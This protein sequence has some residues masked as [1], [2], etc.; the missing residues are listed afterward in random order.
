MQP[1]EERIGERLAGRYRLDRVIG[2]G[3][4]GIVYAATDENTL[5]RVAVKLLRR[6]ALLDADVYQRFQQEAKIVGA[7]GSPHLPK[8]FDFGNDGERPYLVLSLLEGED[9]AQYL[10]RKRCLTLAQTSELVDQLADAL[11]LAHN[12][13]V[14]HYDLKPSNIFLSFNPQQPGSL[15]AVTILDFGVSKLLHSPSLSL[16]TGA[17][18]GTPQYMSPEQAL[19]KHEQ[20]DH[21]TDNFAVAAILYECLTGCRAFDSPTLAGTLYAVCRGHPQSI[22]G[23][24]VDLTAALESF[25]AR[26]LA[27]SP[28]ERYSTIRDMEADFAQI[29]RDF[30]NQAALATPGTPS[31]GDRPITLVPATPKIKRTRMIALV[32]LLLLMIGFLWEVL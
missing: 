17:I 18:L 21:R 31:H 19:G 7:I 22:V 5:Q 29:T 25:F 2:H 20:T 16:Q 8:V 11:A 6:E 23:F 1:G 27:K 26:A 3:G 15:G 9:L 10:A 4:A 13:G 30:A 24:P 32:V 14:V 28:T 12:A